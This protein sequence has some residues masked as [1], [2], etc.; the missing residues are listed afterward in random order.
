MMKTP[1]R[2]LSCACIFLNSH[3]CQ[4]NLNCNDNLNF[5]QKVFSGEMAL[6]AVAY[7][8]ALL[9][10]PGVPHPVHGGEIP[11]DILQPNSCLQNLALVRPNIRQ[12]LLN[13][14]KGLLC[15]L[16]NIAGA[17]ILNDPDL[18]REIDNVPVNKNSAASR[19]S[20]VQTQDARPSS[21]GGQGD[22]D[23]PN[24]PSNYPTHHSCH[25]HLAVHPQAVF[26]SSSLVEVNQAI[27]A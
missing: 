7:T 2:L 13:L 9:V 6:N 4:N 26:S 25:C 20:R 24:E 8:L 12:Q 1:K 11:L 15:L 22:G 23:G 5:D 27:K 14:D 16:D 19:I 3:I 10:N 18:A 21:P 17:N